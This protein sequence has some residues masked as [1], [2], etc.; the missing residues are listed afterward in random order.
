[1]STAADGADASTGSAPTLV[2]LGASGD[3][4]SRLL[5]PALAEL[6]NRQNPSMRLLGSARADWDDDQWR[7]RVRKAFGKAETTPA[8]EAIIRTTHYVKA[9]VT[10][11]EDLDR[12]VRACSAGP[13]ILYFAVAPA[14]AEQACRALSRI[15][16]PATTRLVME[17][18]FGSDAASADALN[19]VM[20]HLVPED[21]IYRVDHYLGLSTVLNIFGLRF[22]NLMLES[23]LDST[24]VASVDILLDESL[25]L[26][27]RAGYYDHAGA[28]VDMLQSHALHV[29]SLLAMEPPASLSA[30]DVRDS[31]AAVLRA[32][33][34][35]GNDP[36][37]SSCRARYTAGV[38]GD[39]AVPGYVD[40]KG[41]DPARGTE[42]FAE[43]VVEVNT[44]RWAGVPFRLRTGKALRQMDKHVVI[45][46]KGPRWVPEGLLGYERPDRMHIGLNP[47]VLRLDFNINGTGDL[48]VVDRVHMGVNLEPGDLP[49]Y[50]QVLAGVLAGDPTL[51]VRGDQAVQTWRIVEPVLRAWREDAVPL[52][53]YQAGS[54]GPTRLSVD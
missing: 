53:D 28:L 24:H 36:V 30:R 8:L 47:E 7:S 40:E 15:A 25:A 51:S 52:Q 43:I 9:D 3:L 5:L 48:R 33:R 35:W 1:M 49:P 29:L 21:Q 22:T 38:V 50:G 42:T 27:N 34:V 23:V 16:L 2:V 46:F 4:T 12:L 14:V 41:V 10:A 26:E 13:L 31:A 17:K 11:S 6:V 54:D 39:R 37:A 44:W 19:Q 32:T 45:T 20:T 18:P